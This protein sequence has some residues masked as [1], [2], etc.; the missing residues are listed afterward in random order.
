MAVYTEI[1]T[2][3]IKGFD[4]CSH[5]HGCSVRA[6][7]LGILAESVVPESS[8]RVPVVLPPDA[9]PARLYHPPKA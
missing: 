9:P 2:V 4:H 3:P 6:S 1:C 5:A 7:S 8:P